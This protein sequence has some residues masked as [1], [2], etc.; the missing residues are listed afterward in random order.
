MARL[1]Q[2]Q[3]AAQVSD[4]RNNVLAQKTAPQH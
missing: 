4:Y 1:S 3:G 2:I